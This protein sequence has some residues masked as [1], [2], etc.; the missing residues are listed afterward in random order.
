MPH[1]DAQKSTIPLK[2]NE[3]SSLRRER[4]GMG[5]VKSTLLE[6]IGVVEYRVDDTAVK[7]A[8]IQEATRRAKP[9]DGGWKEELISI[10]SAQLK[11]R[12]MDYLN[13]KLPD[14][15]ARL[16]EV[17]DSYLVK[18]NETMCTHTIYGAYQ[19]N[20][21]ERDPG[22][23]GWREMR[24]DLRPALTGTIVGAALGVG[25]ATMTVSLVPLGIGA[26]AEIELESKFTISATYKASPGLIRGPDPLNTP[27]AKV[28]ATPDLELKVG[29]AVEHQTLVKTSVTSEIVLELSGPELSGEIVAGKEQSVN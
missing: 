29:V 2:R 15:M 6:G 24:S 23:P 22:D 20:C 21:G 3:Q 18:V 14:P 10:V 28:Q 1:A 5:V 26:D 11:K 9:P 8:V 16:N 12:V 17:L 19:Y 25:P 4:K 7:D 27:T 13:P